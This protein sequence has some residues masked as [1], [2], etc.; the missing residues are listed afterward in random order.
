MYNKQS[1]EIKNTIAFAERL[2]DGLICID[3]VG[4]ENC[5]DIE[6]QVNYAICLADLEA[7]FESRKFKLT[8]KF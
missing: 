1:E 4:Y 5:P 2:R 8:E 7:A 3:E 6:T